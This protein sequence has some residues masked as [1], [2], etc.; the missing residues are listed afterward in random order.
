MNYVDGVTTAC[1]LCGDTITMPSVFV[2]DCVPLV[3]SLIM[4]YV[5]GVT[6]VCTLCGD[7]ITMPSVFVLD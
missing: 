2:Q 1:T 6:T 3:L 5:D 7:I 4:N